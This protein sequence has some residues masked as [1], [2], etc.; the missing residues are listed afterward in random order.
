MKRRKVLIIYWKD[1]VEVLRNQVDL[2]EDDDIFFNYGAESDDTPGHPTHTPFIQDGVQHVKRKLM[3]YTECM[4]SWNDRGTESPRFFAVFVQVPT[5]QTATNLK[6]KA[7]RTYPVHKVFLKF[8][9]SQK[10]NII[11]NSF[12]PIEFMPL[13]TGYLI[14]ESNDKKGGKLTK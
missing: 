12:T 9:L 4:S 13:G 5:N 11:G 10:R 6:A 8:T 1:T 14:E 3:S 2:S 7:L